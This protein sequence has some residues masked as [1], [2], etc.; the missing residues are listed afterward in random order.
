MIVVVGPMFDSTSPIQNLEDALRRLDVSY[1]LRKVLLSKVER[2]PVL[3]Q[4]NIIQFVRMLHYTI[5]GEQVDAGDIHYQVTEDLIGIRD[6]P[7]AHMSFEAAERNYSAEQMILAVVR[8]GNIHGRQIVERAMTFLRRMDDGVRE[9]RRD[10]KNTMII[11]TALCARAAI[12]GGLSVQ[13]ARAMEAK[14][15]RAIERCGRISDLT[16]LYSEMLRDFAAQVHHC[17]E[18]PEI[19]PAIQNC[20]AYI[21]ANLREPLELEDIAKAVGYTEYYLTK[22]FRKEMGIRLVDYIK[23]ARIEQA[24]L[25]LLTDTPVQ[26]ISDELQFSS[27]GYFSKVFKESVGMT[28]A[29]YHSSRGRREQDEA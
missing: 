19:S 23:N 24:K 16:N 14:Y 21:Q 4:A 28:P 1:A 15:I 12:E 6:D 10:A 25:M 29:E 7:E 17:R 11:Y 22:K 20:C 26:E 18:N 13:I 5:Y 3:S 9:P 2:V 27:R 8:E